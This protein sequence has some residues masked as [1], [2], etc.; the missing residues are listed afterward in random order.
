MAEQRDMLGGA[1]PDDLAQA[2][3]SE[4][5]AHKWAPTLAE[6][7]DANVEAF[8]NAGYEEIAERL[9]GIGV[10]ATAF[11]V[12]GRVVYIPRGDRLKQALRD[13]AMHAA[14]QR[15]GDIQRLARDFDVTEPT[16]Y[17]VIAEQRRLHIKRTQRE[18]FNKEENE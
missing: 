10:G 2:D 5:P 11:Q 18:L 15:H 13:N 8:R 6:I 4:L 12:G 7:Y 3:L 14:W 9:A 16:A 17:R 1:T